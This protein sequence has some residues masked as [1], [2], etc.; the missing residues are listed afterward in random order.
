M[1]TEQLGKF[2]LTL[3]EALKINLASCLT[4]LTDKLYIPVAEVFGKF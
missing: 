2:R 3:L 1:G 4:I